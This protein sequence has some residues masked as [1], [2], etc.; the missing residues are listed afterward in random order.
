MTAAAAPLG[1]DLKVMGLV[2]A[3]HWASHFYQLVLPPL[4]LFLKDEFGVSFAALGLLTTLLYGSS[5]LAQT[6]A[7]FAVDRFGARRVLLSG[8]TLAA[9]STLAFG[10]VEAYWLLL[11]LSVLAGLG[12]SVFHP[13]DL[14]IL[15]SK[16]SEGRLGRGYASHALCGNLG[17]AAAPLLMLGLAQLWDWRVAVIC[18]GLMGLVIVAAFLIWGADLADDMARPPRPAGGGRLGS[19]ASSIRLLFSATIVSCFLYFAFLAAA[20]IG[21]QNFGIPAMIDMY[22]VSLV[23]A[24]AAVTWFLV[25]A[26]TGILIGGFAADR[27]SRHDLIAMGGML[28]SALLML[29]VAFGTMPA[30]L[31]ALILAASGAASGIT[32]P[33]RDMLVRAAA[34]K[35]ASGRVFGFVYSGLDLGSSMVPLALGWVLDRGRPEVVFHSVAIFLFITILTVLQVRRQVRPKPAMS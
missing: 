4:F 31:L 25:G 24:T 33:S 28:A 29:Y 11:P 19:L 8:L 16:V 30:A 17:W 35:G 12:N 10:L 26:A 13:A 22:G 9:V 7:G 20:L 2:G 3:A 6:V 18:A 5:G 15:T 14:A 32:T 21:V 1:R 27:T 23:Q 34:P